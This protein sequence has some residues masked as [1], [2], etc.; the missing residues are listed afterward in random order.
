[1]KKYYIL[2]G[3]LLSQFIW[4][5]F[6]AFIS[7]NPNPF[8][9]PGDG[10]V[11]FALLSVVIV[12]VWAITA[13]SCFEEERKDYQNKLRNQR[14]KDNEEMVEYHRAEYRRLSGRSFY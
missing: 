3:F 5:A 10:R 7:L 14:L 2:A 1:M 8:S 4:W 9:W 12:V 6:C 11:L 13:Y